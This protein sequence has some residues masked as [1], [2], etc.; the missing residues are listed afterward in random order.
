[1]LDTVFCTRPSN[2]NP[3]NLVPGTSHEAPE[4]L[5]T[6]PG[7]LPRVKA[8]HEEVAVEYTMPG[9]PPEPEQIIAVVRHVASG[10]PLPAAGS[11]IGAVDEAVCVACPRERRGVLAGRLLRPYEAI[12]EP[13]W[14]LLEQGFVCVGAATRAGC[15]ALCPAVAMPC[16]G[17]YGPLDLD[18]D[19][20]AASL[21]GIA[22]A[23]EPGPSTGRSEATAHEQMRAALAGIADPM[24][25]F[26]RYSLASTVVA[27]RDQE[28]IA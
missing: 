18:G 14:C 22:A 1:M 21:S 15:G 2:D 7:F 11:I 6:L 24:G 5:L 4:G 8:L 3:A 25:T 20:G 26:Y 19:P 12:P 28:T 10:A 16:T 9:C 13:G 27:D 17:C 23:V